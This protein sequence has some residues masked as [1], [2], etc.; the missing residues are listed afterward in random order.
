MDS[1]AAKRQV[2]EIAREPDFEFRLHDLVSLWEQ[3]K[4][5]VELLE[6]IFRFIE[7]HGDLDFGSPG[8]LVHFAENFRGCGYERELLNWLNRR[9]TAH[10]AWMLNR[11][12]NGATDPVERAAF[13]GAHRQARAHSASDPHARSVI[14]IFL[15][16]K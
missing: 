3:T 14:D 11:L 13:V 9:P 15:K 7:E 5:G 6:P 4:D 12:I 2:E 16:D 1:S 10:T 8:R